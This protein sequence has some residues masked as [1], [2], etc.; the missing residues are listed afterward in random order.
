MEELQNI[1][2]ET[3]GSAAA[4]DK[5]EESKTIHPVIRV[6]VFMA[7]FCGIMLLLCSIFEYKNGYMSQRYELYKNLEP[8]TVD[9]VVIGTSGI[10]RSIIP[11]KAF[12]NYGITVYPFSFD[13]LPC[14]TVLD[15]I[16]EA[17]RFQNPKV[18]ALDMRM[19][20]I[21]D[22]TKNLNLSTVRSRRVI[23]TF[24]FFSINRFDVIWRTQKFLN[25]A[26]NNPFGFDISLFLSFVQYHDMWS[27]EGFNPI[28]QIGS[29]ESKYLG[30]YL[31]KRSIKTVPVEPPYRTDEKE[32]LTTIVE[33]C[34]YE[35]LDYCKA[36]G[37]ELMFVNTPFQ[38]SDME[39]KRLN[40]LKDI[41]DERGINYMC[42]TDEEW[43]NING[44]IEDRIIKNADGTYTIHYYDLVLDY[45]EW[46]E[47]IH[48]WETHSINPELHFYDESHLN[49]EGAV[50]FSRMFGIY[51]R[52]RY[53]L[54]DHSGD[55]KFADWDSFNKVKKKIKKYRAAV[56]KEQNDE[57]LTQEDLEEM[58]QE[59]QEL[60]EEDEQAKE[61][62]EEL[63]K[64]E[65]K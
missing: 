39:S 22:Q 9:V 45:D 30:Y 62:K 14:W 28:K 5:A 25:Y 13:G 24:D 49:Y 54:T 6:V 8:D 65:N 26:N 27:E 37:I 59:D 36:E 23:D 33:E 12:E 51:L 61:S 10:D 57:V 50:I 60:R 63:K 35:I 3:A 48:F 44:S 4:P 46:S 7:V 31:T 21:Y 1:K 15:V 58:K 17:Y 32:A 42:Y 2:D 38:M 40:T 34:L 20:T 16:K 43:Y 18:I 52:D 56:L 29:P 11:A 47:A 41:L 64:E 53:G 55:E 19:F